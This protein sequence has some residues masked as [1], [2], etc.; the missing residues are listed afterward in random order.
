MG[1]SYCSRC[2]KLHEDEFRCCAAICFTADS[3]HT[4]TDGMLTDLLS[5]FPVGYT[6]DAIFM[7]RRS[8]SQLIKSRI[9]VN[10]SAYVGAVPG[11]VTDFDGIPVYRT[12][13]IQNTEALR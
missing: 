5:L 11:F 2:R 6:P 7:T 4:L 10:A 9:A 1:W 13:S 3:G 8:M 12:D